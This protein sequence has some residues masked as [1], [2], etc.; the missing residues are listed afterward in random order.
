MNLIMVGFMASGKTSVGRRLAHRLGY[1]FLDTDH[2]IE[3][4]I[5]CTIPE[6]FSIQGEAYF[7]DLE[8]RLASRLHKLENTVISTGGGM[9]ITPGNQERLQAAGVIVFLKA[10][11]Q[12]IIERLK[13]DSRR[14]KARED[15]DLETTVAN[16]MTARLPVYEQADIIL[17]TGG[18][19]V[20]RVCGEIIR[21]LAKYPSRPTPDTEEPAPP[22]TP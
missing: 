17:E 18:K 19:S 5:G 9:I 11:K 13:R 14:P 1:A 21:E 22:T 20:N 15:G 3:S 12:D 7:R 16:L 4:K 8:T 10:R 6:I 2:F